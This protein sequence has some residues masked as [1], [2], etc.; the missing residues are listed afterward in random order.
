MKSHTGQTACVRSPRIFLLTNVINKETVH[1]KAID[2]DADGQIDKK[3]EK[4]P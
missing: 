4:V 2:R 3:E 1:K